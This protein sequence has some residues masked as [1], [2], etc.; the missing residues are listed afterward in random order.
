MISSL[1]TARCVSSTCSFSLPHL[2]LFFFL[3]IRRPPRSTL[4]PYTTLFR[5]PPERVVEHPFC[6]LILVRIELPGGRIRSLGLQAARCEQ[7]RRVARSREL[8]QVSVD[9]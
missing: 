3:M 5:A 9:R 8:R 1:A 7:E 4:F 6:S 2:F